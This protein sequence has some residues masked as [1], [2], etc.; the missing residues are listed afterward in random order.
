MAI[1]Y[2]L[3]GAWCTVVATLTIAFALHHDLPW[4][5]GAGVVL[6][7]LALLSFRFGT[8]APSLR[9]V[10]LGISVAMA[11]WRSADAAWL[12]VINTILAPGTVPGPILFGRWFLASILALCAHAL[13]RCW[14]AANNGWR[15]P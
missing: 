8:L 11:L 9:N 5:I 15:G 14:R 1:T 10:V 13:W 7:F 3:L 2:A 4:I 12:T 6:W